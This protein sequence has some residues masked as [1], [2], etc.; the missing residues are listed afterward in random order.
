MFAKALNETYKAVEERPDKVGSLVRLKEYDNDRYSVWKEP[1]GQV[2]VT[3]HGTEGSNISD[4][5]DDAKIM[6]G[7][8]AHSGDVR[9]LFQRLDTEGLTYDVAAHSLGTQ[10]VQNA[11]KNNADKILLFNPAS[12]PT[13]SGEYLNSL[14]NDERYTYFIN[15]SDVVSKALWQ[16][17]EDEKVGESYISEARYSPLAAHSMSQWVDDPQTD[18]NG[19]KQS[20]ETSSSGDSK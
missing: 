17:M 1:N 13:Q 19:S 16:Q 4:W 3:V 15:P 11:E 5:I 12:S 8:D 6:L 18:E 9:E 7:G 10:F 14:A 20:K 2:L